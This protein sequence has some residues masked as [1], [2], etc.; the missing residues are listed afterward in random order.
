MKMRMIA[1]LAAP[2]TAALL[3][4]C[5][6][7]RPRQAQTPQSVEFETTPCFGSCPVFKITV[8]SDDKGRYEGGRFVAQKG[9]H[10]FTATPKQ[11]EAFF[12]RIGKFRPQGAVRYDIGHCPVP[13]HTDASSVEV[14]WKGPAGEDS[15]HWNLGC[16]DPQLS[17]IQPN[18]Q[19]AWK[20]LPLDDLVGKA[21]N[22]F[23][24]DQRGK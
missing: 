9:A 20:E 5:S 21:E 6:D 15:L 4:G 13:A 24:Y 8:F 23:E 11:L 14:R 17:A 1:L 7:E 12:D 22:R 2:L 19:E 3:A 16:R 10:E 18:L